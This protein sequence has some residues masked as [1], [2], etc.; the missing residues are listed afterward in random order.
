MGAGGGGGIYNKDHSMLGS[1]GSPYL[2]K[3]AYPLAVK[4]AT[5]S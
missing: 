2:D 1:S 3:L 4:R 5:S